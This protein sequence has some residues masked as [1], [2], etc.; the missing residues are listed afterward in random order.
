MVLI[1][2]KRTN[3]GKMKI[4][5]ITEKHFAQAVYRKPSLYVIRFLTALLHSMDITVTHKKSI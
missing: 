4:P 2:D 5:K 3:N 1:S